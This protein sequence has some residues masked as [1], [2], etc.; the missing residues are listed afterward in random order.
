MAESKEDIIRRGYKAFGEGDMDTFRSSIYTPDVVQHMPG[1]NQISGE[2]KGVDNVLGLY[3]Q[4]FELSGGTFAVDLKSVKTQGDK[5]VSVHRAKAEREGKTLDA[6]ET[7]EFTF[8]GDKVSRLDL[9]SAD[10]AAE[11]AFWG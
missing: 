7:I 2:H 6:D 8:S 3:G 1:S 9:T 5:V 4:L 10:Q 11:D